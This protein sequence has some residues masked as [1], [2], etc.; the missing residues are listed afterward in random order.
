MVIATG[1]DVAEARARAEAAI[2]TLRIV[3]EETAESRELAA[4]A[5]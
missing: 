5:L 1:N 2:N 3:M 4:M